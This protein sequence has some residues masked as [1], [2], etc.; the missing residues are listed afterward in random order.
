MG[1]LH[2]RYAPAPG[3]SFKAVDDAMMLVNIKDGQCY[4]LNRTGRE[5]WNAIAEGHPPADAI[6]AI[7]APG[8]D[9]SQVE[10]DVEALVQELVRSSLLVEANDAPPGNRR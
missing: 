10:A 4:E 1:A 9:R 2:T 5:I 6:D 8:V 3:V 7:D